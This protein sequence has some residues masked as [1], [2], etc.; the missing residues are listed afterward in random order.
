MLSQDL[1]NFVDTLYK[2]FQLM[3]VADIECVDMIVDE[4]TIWTH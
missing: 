2:V 4:S 1:E 3:Y